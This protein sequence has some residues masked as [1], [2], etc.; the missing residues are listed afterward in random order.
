MM[1][2]YQPPPSSQRLRGL[3]RPRRGQTTH[4]RSGSSSSSYQPRPLGR[5]R[6]PFCWT[7]WTIT[8]S[9]CS[10]RKFSPLRASSA[11]ESLLRGTSPTTRARAPIRR[12]RSSGTQ[13]SVLARRRALYQPPSDQLGRSRCR[14]RPPCDDPCPTYFFCSIGGARQGVGGARGR[15]PKT[16]HL[17]HLHRRRARVCLAWGDL[18]R[19]RRPTI[20][21]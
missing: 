19:L 8:L 21:V 20:S 9:P 15:R 16:R 4:K 18:G 5:T 1:V 7:A 13:R 10:R 14:Y 12:T 11:S 17:A 3:P 2:C 6:A